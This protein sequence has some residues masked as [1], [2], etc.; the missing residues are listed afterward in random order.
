L[1]YRAW[2]QAENDHPQYHVFAK[3]M[4]F[5][6]RLILFNIVVEGHDYFCALCRIV[7]EYCPEN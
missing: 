2:E 4:P 6:N 7:Q 3:E 1:C 5:S